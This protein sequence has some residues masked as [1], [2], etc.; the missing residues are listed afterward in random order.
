MLAGP[1]W[2]A[3]QAGERGSTRHWNRSVHQANEQQMQRQYVGCA[4]Q[5]NKGSCRRQGCSCWKIQQGIA[6]A[7][8]PR[9]RLEAPVFATLHRDPSHLS[10][11]FRQPRPDPRGDLHRTARRVRSVIVQADHSTLLQVGVALHD[12]EDNGARP[13]PSWEPEAGHMRQKAVFQE[14]HHL[15]LQRAGQML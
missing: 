13:G 10:I 11:A 9:G 5:R 3:R 8:H 15:A 14:E 6:C 4:E 1:V 12:E 7:G 2:Q